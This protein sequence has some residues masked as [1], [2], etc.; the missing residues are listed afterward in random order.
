[1]T[2]A[3]SVHVTSV[4]RH[5]DDRHDGWWTDCT[6]PWDAGHCF[7]SEWDA[8]C[9]ELCHRAWVET[10]V[11]RAVTAGEAQEMWERYGRPGETTPDMEE[12]HQ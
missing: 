8:R 2:A 1:M 4:T 7:R 6:C 10:G 11:D 5:R 3:T 12:T 9:A